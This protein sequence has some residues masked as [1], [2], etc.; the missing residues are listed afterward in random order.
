MTRPSGTA[1][2]SEKDEDKEE[3]RGEGLRASMG[4]TAWDRLDTHDTIR[5]DSLLLDTVPSL[6]AFNESAI[7]T[8]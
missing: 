5:Y 2:Q 4:H 8:L 7:V 6:L 1:T 3:R